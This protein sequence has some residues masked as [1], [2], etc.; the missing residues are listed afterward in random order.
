MSIVVRSA[1]EAAEL[2]SALRQQAYNCLDTCLTFGIWQA[3]E[4]KL[5]AN[6]AA[7]LTY[8]FERAMQGPA[9]T[10]ALRGIRV[11]EEAAAFETRKLELAET[12]CTAHL[13]ALA[14]VWLPDEAA[15]LNPLSTAQV[16]RLLFEATGEVPYREGSVDEDA[17]MM[18]QA[19][20]PVIGVM[21]HLVLRIREV[22]KQLSFL[23]AKRSPDGRMRS[24]FNVGAT[25]G[26]RWSFSRNCFGDGL[27]FGN[28]PK[29]RRTMFVPEPGW[30]MVNTDLKQAESYIVG[31]LCD[32]A[33]VRAHE[34]GD[35]HSAVA[36]DLFGLSDAEIRRPGFIRH[37][38]AR[39]AAKRIGHGTNYGIGPAKSSKITGLPR[40]DID[41]FRAAFFA[42][43]PGIKA[44][45]DSMPARFSTP[46]GNAYVSP[47]G[48]WHQHLGHPKDEETFRTALAILPQ[49]IVADALCK[50]LWRL[51]FWHDVGVQEPRIR[52][53]CQ[54]Y[55]SI[56]LEVREDALQS[57]AEAVERALDVTIEINGKPRKIAHDFGSG[58]NWKEA[59]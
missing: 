26:G 8:D 45:I 12:R 10:M 15:T 58:R 43:Y 9:F 54:N 44:R 25:T 7:Q 14:A 2:P 1:A 24:S 53:L 48:R 16:R 47:T 33:Y 39:D 27:N 38:S 21:A 36:R 4:P 29:S 41:R 30:V 35:A 42:A 56:L 23:R 52:L 55:D 59:C 37:L 20:S 13:R 11:D 18:L 28:I 49:S 50:A 32:E 40:S 5:A 17:L 19:R 57:A 6:P 3:L 31:A 22:R 51:W 34:T 46:K